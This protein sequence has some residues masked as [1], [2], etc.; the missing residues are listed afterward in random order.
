MKIECGY[1]AKRQAAWSS[2]LSTSASRVCFGRFHFAALLPCQCSQCARSYLPSAAPE[3]RPRVQQEGTCVDQRAGRAKPRAPTPKGRSAWWKS[4]LHE[5]A[6]SKYPGLT[7]NSA[8]RGTASRVPR[9]GSAF[10][11]QGDNLRQVVGRRSAARYLGPHTCSA[12]I[13]IHVDRI[14]LDDAGEQRRRRAAAYELPDGHLARRY[15]AVKR[16]G[17]MRVFK[18][19]SSQVFRLREIGLTRARVACD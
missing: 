5:V 7:A 6:P 10:R 19:Q 3:S 13:E 9:C 2:S 4:A 8:R 15:D 16:G 12:D 17:D 18:V 1:H 11:L 14:V